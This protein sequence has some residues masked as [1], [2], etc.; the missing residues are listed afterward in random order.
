MEAQLLSKALATITRTVKSLLEDACGN[1]KWTL[2][3]LMEAHFIGT[4]RYGDA[5]LT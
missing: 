2:I 4:L 3:E 5:H 1:Y